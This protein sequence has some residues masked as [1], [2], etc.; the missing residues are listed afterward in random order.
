[1]LKV[2]TQQAE[3]LFQEPFRVGELPVR[4]T[5]HWLRGTS[6]R[7]GPRA[8]RPDG[9]ADEQN[10]TAPSKLGD[11]QASARLRIPGRT[12]KEIKIYVGR[13]PFGRIVG[14]AGIVQTHHIAFPQ[15]HRAQEHCCPE[16]PF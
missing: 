15:V 12:F 2:L 5:P 4:S 1:M 3:G 10:I 13:R 8:E 9:Q 6:P 7:S 11:Y 16:A 14:G